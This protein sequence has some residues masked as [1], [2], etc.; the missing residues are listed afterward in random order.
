MTTLLKSD[1][2]MLT[3]LAMAGGELETHLTAHRCPQEV[4]EQLPGPEHESNGTVWKTGK[5]GR[6]TWTAFRADSYGD[7][8]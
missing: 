7:A 5:V 6:F 1:D 4:Y 2:R 3:L 8:A